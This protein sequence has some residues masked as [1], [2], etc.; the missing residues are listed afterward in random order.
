MGW[1]DT[2]NSYVIAL[3]PGDGIG[4]EVVGAAREVLAALPGLRFELREAP[5]GVTALKASGTPLPESSLEVA[6]GADAVLH[7][8]SDAAAIPPGL[9]NPISGLRRALDA[10]ANVR[11]ARSYPGVPGAV[12]GADL[13]VVREN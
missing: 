3:L 2:V 7:G 10:Y 12:P 6:R 1:T 9:P 11:P 8:A 13:V 4:P 5:V